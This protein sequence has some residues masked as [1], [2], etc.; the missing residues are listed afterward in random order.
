MD[1]PQKANTQAEL[2]VCKKQAEE[3]L[4]GWKRA[5][6]DYINF[7]RQVEKEKAQWMSLAVL[8][9]VLELV[10]LAEHLDQAFVHAPGGEPSEEMKNWVQGIAHTRDDMKG[11]L[12]NLQ[13]EKIET[14]GKKLDLNLMEVAGKEKIKEQDSGTVVREVASGY[15]MAGQ[16]IKVAKVVVAEE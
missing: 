15:T 6:A 4:N 12:K 11:L 3:Y 1:E 2:E 16:V 7:E 9:V 5:K 8:P 10:T 14:A 13:V